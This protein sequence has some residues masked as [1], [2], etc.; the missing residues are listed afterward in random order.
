MRTRW[1]GAGALA[2]GLLVVLG[3]SAGPGSTPSAYAQT[4]ESDE[5]HCIIITTL[6]SEDGEFSFNDG[7]IQLGNGESEAINVELDGSLTV[8][9]D[10]TDGWV[11]EGI[12]CEDEEFTEVDLEDASV[13]FDFSD[14]D[15]QEDPLTIECVFINA[16]DEAASAADEDADAADEGDEADEGD[17]ADTA[18]EGD[19]ADEGDDADQAN[20]AD[21]DEATP[22]STATSTSNTATNANATTTP[23]ETPMIILGNTGNPSAAQTPTAP[24]PRPATSQVQ[25]GSIS[26]PST[27][28]GGL[29]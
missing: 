20:A 11:L 28:S 21:D 5:E 4:C 22:T 26:P 25:A 2:A 29:K 12:D 6:A 3:F 19:E 13:T 15:D 8:T 24:T 27:G 23:S 1:M 18:D 14:F 16:E 10:E 7:D 9:E 17:D